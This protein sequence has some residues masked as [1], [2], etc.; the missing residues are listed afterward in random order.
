MQNHRAGAPSAPR[1]TPLFPHHKSLHPLHREE[2]ERKPL[3]VAPG[4]P[5]YAPDA[6]RFQRPEPAGEDPALK[7]TAGVLS[8]QRVHPAVPRAHKLSDGALAEHARKALDISPDA[9]DYLPERERLARVDAAAV[10]AAARA[11]AAAQRNAVLER[12][13][14]SGGAEPAPWTKE[15][16]VL[17]QQAGARAPR[18]PLHA[19]Q[20]AWDLT[21]PLLT[22]Q[23][24]SAAGPSP[25]TAAARRLI[26]SPAPTRAARRAPAW[27]SKTRLPRRLRPSSARRL[28]SAP[29]ARATTC[30]PASRVRARPACAA[31]CR[32]GSDALGGGADGTRPLPREGGKRTGYAGAQR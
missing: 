17:L 27:R 32:A 9:S 28:P 30:S 7:Q 24:R 20:R 23:R 10:E 21:R 26:P 6:E 11:A 2:N 22:A 12:K 15:D 25:S 13:R 29:P 8:S 31:R 1:E 14:A 3:E 19:T 18:R 4:V 5:G 16:A